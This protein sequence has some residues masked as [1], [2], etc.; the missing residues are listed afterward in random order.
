MWGKYF[1]DEVVSF[2]GQ[3]NDKKPAVGFT[4][5]A[6]DQSVL[7]DIWSDNEEPNIIN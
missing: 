4:A 3:M 6:P 2:I 5:L 7:I 1:V